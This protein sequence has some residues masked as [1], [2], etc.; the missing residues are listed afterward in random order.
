MSIILRFYPV[1][2]IWRKSHHTSWIAT[3][4]IYVF[5]KLILK[6]VQNTFLGYITRKGSKAS[7][8]SATTLKHDTFLGAW[9]R[10]SHNCMHT[11]DS[12][13]LK[14][15][16]T[17]IVVATEIS[18][19][20]YFTPINISSLFWPGLQ[21]LIRKHVVMITRWRQCQNTVLDSDFEQQITVEKLSHAIS[22]QFTYYCWS[23]TPSI[24][25]LL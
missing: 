17:L 19:K 2:S 14:L 4:T 9:L 10:S 7:N 15:C 13:S 6:S 21:W 5:S 18:D 23:L 20:F 24:I 25:F 1:G 22:L 3:S 8:K 16:W 12:D 11:I